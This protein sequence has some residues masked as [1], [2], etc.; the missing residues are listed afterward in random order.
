MQ[1]FGQGL[2][3]SSVELID[4]DSNKSIDK[5]FTIHQTLH[6]AKLSFTIF[7]SCEYLR[8]IYLQEFIIQLSFTR[9]SP[10]FVRRKSHSAAL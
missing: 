2:F 7:A 3:D 9:F 4:A 6:M 8:R 5:V 1:E 10:C